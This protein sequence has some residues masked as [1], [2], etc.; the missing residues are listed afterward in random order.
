MRSHT[1]SLDKRARLLLAIGALS[2]LVLLAAAL[3]DFTFAPAQPLWQASTPTVLPAFEEFAEGYAHAPLW[4]QF[5]FWLLL[6]LLFILVASLLSPDQRKRLIRS[7]LTFVATAWILTY[8]LEN[9]LLPLESLADT[10]P[11]TLP[12]NTP[13]GALPPPPIFT[14]PDVPTWQVYLVTF[15]LLAVLLALGWGLLTWRKRLTALRAAA[16]PLDDLA[17]IARASLNDLV[18]G[19]D[20]DDAILRC[21]VRM[22]A[23]V[24][25]KRGLARQ[26]AMT[27]TEFA[28]RLEQAG[29][30]SQPVQRLTRLFEAVRYGARQAQPAEIHE[31]TDCLTAILRACGET[32]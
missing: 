15:G 6:A 1:S 5:L 12:E 25:R 11:L 32:P 16:R 8:L 4:K 20:A 17:A 24:E 30:P 14:P 21:Y 9:R 2:A 23:V 19:Q 18:Q 10:A 29:L 28:R 27:P 7:A 3:H 31:A 13:S 22:S 26:P